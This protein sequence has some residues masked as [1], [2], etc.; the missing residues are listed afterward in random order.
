MKKFSI[1]WRLFCFTAV[2]WL[3]TSCISSP[4]TILPSP[5]LPSETMQPPTAINTSIPTQTLT[6]TLLSPSPTITSAPTLTAQERETYVR[7]LLR[8]NASCELPCWWGIVPGATT[9]KEAEQFLQHV[10]AIVASTS[11]PDKS[12]IV[13][14]TGGFDF[15]GE[16]I[17][18]HYTTVYNDIA[19]TELG[20]FVT[21]V[22]ISSSGSAN[23]IEF[24]SAFDY[25]S[26]QQVI[27]KYG[28]PSRVWMTT[29][30]LSG[31]GNTGKNGYDLWM[32][33]DHLGF[34]IGYEGRVEDAPIYHVC[35][36][37]ENGEDIY[38]LDL[39]LQSPD[40]P[41]PIEKNDS[42]LNSGG[43]SSVLN[44]ENAAGISVEEFY[45][46]FIQNDQPACFDTPRD[47]WP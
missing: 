37:F 1:T 39:Y 45:E 29:T 15:E 11:G 14:E 22:H 32:F 40:D 5:I 19:F 36:R 21:S 17:S 4:S 24:Q 31:Y 35:P 10:G 41:S 30:S 23:P 6:P 9:W 46:L 28:K 34:L 7:E 13:H 44:I 12:T 25:Y 47:I 43:R 18:D 42:I 3:V 27:T 8:T 20:G 2:V 26:P 16:Y 38:S 33:F